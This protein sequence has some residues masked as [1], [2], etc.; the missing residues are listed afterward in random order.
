MSKIKFGLGALQAAQENYQIILDKLIR[1]YQKMMK[2]DPEGL[3]LIKIKQEARQRAD[4]SAKV[5]DMGG[6]T[7]NP[8]KPIMGGTQDFGED[9]RKIYDEAKGPGK[10]DE[11]VE[12]MKSP[13][14]RASTDIIEKQLQETFPDIKLFGDET[15]EEIL[16]I[17]KTGKHPRMKADGGRI[18]FAL[19]GP[20]NII[21]AGLGSSGL[22]LLGGIEEEDEFADIQGQTAGLG[23][24]GPISKGIQSIFGPKIGSM[25][26][27]NYVRRPAINKG[28]DAVKKA[29]EIA[30]TKRLELEEKLA[31]RAA[32]AA[33]RD[34][35]NRMGYQ[36]YG[37]GAASAET[38]ASYEGADG[39]YAGASTQD[40]G[41]GEKDG[42]I[43]GY[44]KGGIAT[45]FVRKR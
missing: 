45:M 35:I 36:D 41:G 37:S 24:F 1:G 39:S 2:K 3:D 8:E 12:A 34:E 11:M 38:Q 29:N 16:E 7:L 19:G 23:L 17:Q 43:I 33:A 21:G 26:F 9:I 15:F 27:E 28:M 6:K 18:N 32:L 40:Y 44:Q 14:A 13:G 4:E 10:G 31:K 42:G 20:T 30:Y 25:V 22:G 5:V